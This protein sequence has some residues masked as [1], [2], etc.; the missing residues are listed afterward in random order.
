MTIR[1]TTSSVP[2]AA[3]LFAAA[4]IAWLVV[5]AQAGGMESAPGTMGFSALAF[6]GL[7]TVMMA[8]MMLPALAPVGV[9]YAGDGEGRASRAG[10]LAAGYLIAWA[11][12]GV[13]ALLL[14]IAAKDLADRNESAATWIGAAVLVATGAYQ[15]SPLKDR[16]L[17]ACRSPL[18]LL[19]RTGA[20]RGPT[21]HVRA[22]IYHGV[23][24]VACCWSLMVALIALGIMDLRWMVAFA[25]VITLEK[26]WRYGRIVALAAGIALIAL[27]LAV[28]SH[29]GIVPGLHNSPMSMESM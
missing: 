7:W 1:A 25:V 28:P 11:A 12:F 10:G 15:L 14:S 4:A 9:L 19:M 21:R 22:G 16:C 6:L 23:Y 20:Y 29:P 2:V 24:C 17:A 27:G 8:A 26:L 18:Q 13:L 3:G 5:V